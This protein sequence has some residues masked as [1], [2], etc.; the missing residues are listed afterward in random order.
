[1]NIYSVR[2]NGYVFLINTNIKKTLFDVI[3]DEYMKRGK[4]EG[5]DNY[6][7]ENG[8][9]FIKKECL[10]VYDVDVCESNIRHAGPL[11]PNFKP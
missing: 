3:F 4:K 10:A 6:L 7:R 5:F 8:V 2:E 1:M 9:E 11:G